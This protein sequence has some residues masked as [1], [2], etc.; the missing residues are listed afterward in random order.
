MMRNMQM[1]YTVCVSSCFPCLLCQFC[2][3]RCYIITLSIQRTSIFY[4]LLSTIILYFQNETPTG[5]SQWMISRETLLHADSGQCDKLCARDRKCD[6]CVDWF[7]ALLGYKF[8]NM[9]VMLQWTVHSTQLV[10][11]CKDVNMESAL[12]MKS[13]SVSFWTRQD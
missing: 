7:I 12:E 2:L 6:R 3:F 11:F 13:Y 4:S 9:G 5:S 1:I 10:L 8:G